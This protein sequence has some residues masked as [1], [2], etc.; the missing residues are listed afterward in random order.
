[1]SR[2]HCHP[3]TGLDNWTGHRFTDMFALLKVGEEWQII[4]EVFHLHS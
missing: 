4:S 2:Q 1:M 3:T